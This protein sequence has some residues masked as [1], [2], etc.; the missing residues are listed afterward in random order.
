MNTLTKKR[1]A[2]ILEGLAAWIAEDMHGHYER[3]A[4]HFAYETRTQSRV[5]WEKLPD[6]HRRL[7]IAAVQA[8]L[9][10]TMRRLCS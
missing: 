8:A 1:E 6:N 5:S 4:P 2:L 3:L 7:M 9:V 10:S